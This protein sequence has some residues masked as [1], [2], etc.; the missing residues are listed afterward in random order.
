[1]LFGQRVGATLNVTA[2]LDANDGRLDRAL[3]GEA[4]S[5][6]IVAVAPEQEDALARLAAEHD[7]PLT[8]LGDVGGDELIV[9]GLTRGPIAELR[10]AWAS[11][12]GT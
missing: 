8:R 12:L 1:M 5:R 11:G 2:A 9:G 10:A 4:A 3:F 6:V 7:V